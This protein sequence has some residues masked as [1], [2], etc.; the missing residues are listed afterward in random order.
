MGLKSKIISSLAVFKKRKQRGNVPSQSQNFSFTDILSKISNFNT[1]KETPKSRVNIVY[2]FGDYID[3][4]IAFGKLRK[5]RVYLSKGLSKL[6]LKPYLS[7]SE[8]QE[9]DVISTTD[10]DAKIIHRE[11]APPIFVLE[12]GEDCDRMFCQLLAML[13]AWSTKNYPLVIGVDIFTSDELNIMA[14]N[15]LS[16]V[17]QH[18]ALRFV[19]YNRGIRNIDFLNIPSQVNK[20]ISQCPISFFSGIS[21]EER[22]FNA[23]IELRNMLTQA[24]EENAKI[25]KDILMKLT[26]DNL[27]GS[28]DNIV[29]RKMN[30]FDNSIRRF[31][32]PAVM[33]YRM[34]FCLEN[35]GSYV[36]YIK[37]ENKF[38]TTEQ[39]ILVTRDTEIML[40]SELI[41]KIN[42]IN[43]TDC[44]LPKIT[45]VE[46]V[47]GSG[48]SEYIVKQHSP[49][50]DLILAQTR[51]GIKDIK[52]KIVRN[53]NG[54]DIS[55]DYRTLASYIINGSSKTYERV[56]IDEGFMF[57]AGYIGFIA[58][59]S[60]ISEVIVLGDSKQIPYIERSR[61][62]PRWGSLLEFCETSVYLNTTKRCP[63]D[64][65]FAL[66]HQYENIVTTSGK[67]IS[68]L[69]TARE[70]EFH[71][72][73]PNTLI[74]TF[75]QAE[76]RI[77]QRTLSYYKDLHIYSIHE[78]Q[79]LTVKN[80][81]LV[82]IDS[83]PAEIYDSIP[84]AVVALTRHTESFKYLTTGDED[85]VLR[86][87]RRL[88][89]M[90]EKS[91]RL[92][93]MSRFGA[94]DNYA[95]CYG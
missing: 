66:S 16:T 17:L 9:L 69:P 72:I 55:T 12:G 88:E 52:R 31:L 79:G 71:L 13:N 75:T 22:Y 42:R 78:A 10:M 29:R 4:S 49:G 28:I 74:L 57:H 43:I 94:T 41:I 67:N 25:Y 21:K 6:L 61:A 2:N 68:I 37:S 76:K 93:S 65:C 5:E 14:I 24:D 18:D 91:L 32:F 47:P 30:I 70:G 45:L 64:V 56:F 83:K 3:L 34:G 48:K 11:P 60:G 39:F 73:E 46:G 38:N 86:I 15:L 85:E 51:A 1:T 63:V 54:L 26:A 89:H 59:L 84:H 35:G 62:K 53:F 82:R 19:F 36:E 23:M 58:Q 8:W 80:V 77:L 90:D 7:M 81:V 40:N 50:R 95:G 44:K 87:I 20:E 33:Q 27:G 92:W